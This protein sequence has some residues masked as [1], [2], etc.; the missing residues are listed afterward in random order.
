MTYILNDFKR[1]YSKVYVAFDTSIEEDLDAINLMINDMRLIK[2][3]LANI[4]F[5]DNFVESKLVEHC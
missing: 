3:F 4:S 2:L 1:A 5:D